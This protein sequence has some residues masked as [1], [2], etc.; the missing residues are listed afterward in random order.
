VTVNGE[1]APLFYVDPGQIDAQIPWDIPGN[2]LATVVVKNG[3][4]VTNAAAVYI[5]ATGTPGISVY[6]NNRAVV[7]NLNGNVNSGTDTASVGDEVVVYFTGGGPVTAAGKLTTGAPS[8]A[9]LSPV[10][11]S[12]TITVN[13]VNA[14][15]DYIG[16]TPG[17]IG[18]YQA[19][20]VVP[21]VPKG[22]YPVVIT[23]AG[24]P[25]NNP[26][27]TVAN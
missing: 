8:P 1:P 14:K 25:S 15:V 19:N 11:G 16:L 7:V 20:F 6:G 12:S 18:L 2:T 21:N 13:G 27:M 23:I 3:T 26:V 10:S 24:T 4:A 17:S 9:G 22:T 5:P